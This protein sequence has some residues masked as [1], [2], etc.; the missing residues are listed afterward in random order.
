MNEASA[1]D[2]QPICFRARPQVDRFWLRVCSKS[3]QPGC[4]VSSP[5]CIA[6]PLRPTGVQWRRPGDSELQHTGQCLSE[7]YGGNDIRRA[8]E[9]LPLPGAGPYVPSGDHLELEAR[10]VSGPPRQ[11]GGAK[12]LRRL[13]PVCVDATPHTRRSAG[14]HGAEVRARFAR[15]SQSGKRADTR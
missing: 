14:S 9:Q 13:C 3:S 8:T 6:A 10:A 7:R 5:G 4:G 12:V 15:A 1:H 2:R 11:G